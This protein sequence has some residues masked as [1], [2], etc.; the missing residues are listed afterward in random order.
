MDFPRVAGRSLSGADMV[1]PEDLPAA[2]TL[3]L[4][5]FQQRHQGCVDRWIARAESAGVPGSPVDMSA[6]DETCVVEIPVLSTRWKVGRGFIDGGMASSIRIP[7]VLA[8]TI[9]VYTNV[10]A[11]QKVLGIPGSDEVQACV[12]TPAGEVL[13]RVP[14]EPTDAAWEVIAE[15]LG[16]S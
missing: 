6:D 1:L 4:V 8:R 3:A 15:A 10:S 16:R 9:T 14:G 12:V 11:F 5:A 2:R 13:A 7:R